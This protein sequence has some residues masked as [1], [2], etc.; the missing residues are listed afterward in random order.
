MMTVKSLLIF[1]SNFSTFK[2]PKKLK[3]E[4][5]DF[6]PLFSGSKKVTKILML[7][8]NSVQT[9]DSASLH[10]KKTYPLT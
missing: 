2:F 5:L 4:S 7:G 10:E 9:L 6:F 3:G 8:E 1:I